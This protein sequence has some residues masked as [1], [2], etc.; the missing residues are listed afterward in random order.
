MCEADS[1]K[2]KWTPRMGELVAYSYGSEW[3]LGV[4]HHVEDGK[5]DQAKFF[6]VQ[7]IPDMEPFVYGYC[8]PAI[9][10]FPELR[11]RKLNKKLVA[12]STYKNW[13]LGLLCDEKIMV[14]GSKRYLVLTRAGMEASWYSECEPAANRFPDLRIGE[15]ENEI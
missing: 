9:S 4:F 1:T 6:Y 12:V 10:R 13:Y 3:K 11:G 5:P 7:V 2:E 15:Q 8:E 14:D